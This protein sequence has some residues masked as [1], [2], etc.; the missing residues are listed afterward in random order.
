MSTIPVAFP[1]HEDH[2]AHERPV[3]IRN[4]A[5]NTDLNRARVA[6]LREVM[7]LACEW[8]RLGAPGKALEVL[9][10]HLN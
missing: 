2:A 9:E 1:P 5:A 4:A 6:H 7:R 10:G 3:I 8:L